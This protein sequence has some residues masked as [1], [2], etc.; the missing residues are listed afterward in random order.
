VSMYDDLD[1]PFVPAADDSL[2]A[3]AARAHRLRTRR[4]LAIAGTSA[5][6]VVVAVLA[7]VAFASGGSSP[8]RLTVANSVTSTTHASTTFAPSTRITTPARPK[9]TT[10]TKVPATTVP[11]PVTVP[12]TVPSHKTTS[13]TVP[14]AHLTVSFASD[15]PTIQSGTSVT[16]SYKVSNT[17]RGP[18]RFTPSPCPESQLWPRGE[19]RTQPLLWPVPASPAVDICNGQV[20]PITIAAHGSRTFR[21][22]LVGGLVDGAGNLVP[23]PPGRTTVVVGNA[24][25]PVTIAAPASAPLTVVHPAAVTTASNAQHWVDWTVTNH[26]PFPVR[27]VDQGPCSQDIGIP[28]NATTPDGS[29]TGDLRLP[30]YNTATKPLYLTHFLLGAG[31]T[32]AARAQV[33]GTTTLEDIDLGSPAMPPGVYYFDWDG[34]KVQFTVTPATS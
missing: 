19:S 26:L 32:E 3:V 30:P 29:I 10:S 16:I 4:R 23:A 31:Q 33:H 11:V 17:G 13:T 15:R 25:L 22:K 1:P 18:G 12:T 7:G 28:C 6:V 2:P 5:A 27:Y 24:E 20:R 21:L 34:Q 8:H 14:A 9:G